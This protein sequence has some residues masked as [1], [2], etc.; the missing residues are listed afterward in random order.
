MGIKFVIL[1]CTPA[2]WLSGSLL[3]FKVALLAIAWTSD[4]LAAKIIVTTLIGF[5]FIMAF[6]IPI[7]MFGIQNEFR[8]LL[9]IHKSGNHRTLVP[10]SGKPF[11]SFHL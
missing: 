4:T 7:S 5:A 1:V 3:A 11:F 8:H 6:A 10:S 9:G 2:A